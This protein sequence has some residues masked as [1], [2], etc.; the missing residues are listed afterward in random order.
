MSR[1]YNVIT[2]RD[3]DGYYFASAPSLPGSHTQAHSL[4]ELSERIQEAIALH[5]EVEGEPVGTLD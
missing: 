2:E 3:E 1:N 5:L 4:D